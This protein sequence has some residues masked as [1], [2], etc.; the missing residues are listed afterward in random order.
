MMAQ[1][2]NLDEGITIG[3]PVPAPARTCYVEA[4]SD[5]DVMFDQIEYLLDHQGPACGPECADCARL[6]QVKSALLSP[7][8]PHRH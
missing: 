6:W 2:L 5:I 3:N 4:A 1:L 7:F 8:L